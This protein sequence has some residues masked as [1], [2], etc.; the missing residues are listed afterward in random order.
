MKIVCNTDNLQSAEC[1]V[2]EYLR[3]KNLSYKIVPVMG[4]FEYKIASVTAPIVQDA[5]RAHLASLCEVCKAE[6]AEYRE[7][8][9]QKKLQKAK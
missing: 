4:G 6:N 8:M 7:K 2:E 5:V 3:T 9:A 1:T